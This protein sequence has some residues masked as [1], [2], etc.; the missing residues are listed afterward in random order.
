MGCNNSK[1]ATDNVK[2]PE[3]GTES[4]I[5]LMGHKTDK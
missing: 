3:P 5:K 1:A 2:Q 4:A